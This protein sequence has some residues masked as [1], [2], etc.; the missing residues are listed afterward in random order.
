MDEQT[1]NKLINNIKETNLNKS[2][3]WKKHL[4]DGSDYLNQFEH[5]GFGMFT[6]KSVKNLIH[7]IL[8]KI[9]FGNEVFK[10]KTY[11]AYKSI[12][13]KIERYI[14]VDTIR[15]IF[16]FEKIKEHL[17]PKTICIIGDGKLNG[18]LG[19]HLTFPSANIYSVNL[20]EVLI[21]DYIILD[22]IN[23]DLKKSVELIDNINFINNNK[24]LTLVPSNYKKFLLNKNIELFINIA[25]F[26][27]M[28]KNEINSYFEII[29]NNQSKLY[30]CNREY[31]KLP[32]GEELYFDKYPFS[33][34]RK[35]FWE[36][37]PWHQKFYS[38]RPPFI[39]NYD[40]N[41]KHCLVDFS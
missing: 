25:S 14:D 21:N 16:T 27:E 37:C 18:V 36:N 19:A 39:H 8:A 26:Q 9:I 15:H 5:L 41:I 20:S 35:I 31:K 22:K 23:L 32:D 30:C 3:H 10:T 29:K 4:P 12:F 2:S 11:Y 13:D 17:N 40:G 28:T 1:I 38:L 34:S 6:K 7:N 33:N 24:I